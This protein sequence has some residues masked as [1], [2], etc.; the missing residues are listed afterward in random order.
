MGGG[1]QICIWTLE[2]QGD[3]I[4]LLL[5][6]KNKESTLKAYIHFPSMLRLFVYMKKLKWTLHFIFCFLFC[7]I[8]Y[9]VVCLWYIKRLFTYSRYKNNVIFVV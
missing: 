3:L 7:F 9:T 4:S 2:Q 1:I 5:F 6:F 8:Y